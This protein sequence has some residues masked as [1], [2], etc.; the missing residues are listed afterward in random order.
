QGQAA[1]RLGAMALPRELT[2][3]GCLSGVRPQGVRSEFRSGC[4]ARAPQG[5]TAG[6]PLRQVS[7]KQS[8]PRAGAS[9]GY[10]L[11]AKQRK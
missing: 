10:F 9:F 6:S 2:R 4:L 3:C 11:L 1:A 7:K 5:A 8:V